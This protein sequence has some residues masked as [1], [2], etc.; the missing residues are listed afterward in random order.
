MLSSVWYERQD[1]VGVCVSP[2]DRVENVLHC[3]RL[4]SVAGA[5]IVIELLSAAVDVHH[6]VARFRFLRESTR[7]LSAWSFAPVPVAMGHP[8]LFQ[9]GA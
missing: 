3:I 1:A 5:A 7:V 2:M 9:A 6:A 8:R 4:H